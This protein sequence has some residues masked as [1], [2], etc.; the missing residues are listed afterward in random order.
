MLLQPFQRAWRGIVHVGEQRRQREQ[1]VTAAAPPAPQV[2]LTGCH[3]D[4]RAPAQLVSGSQT[5]QG[6]CKTARSWSRDVP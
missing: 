2:R 6:V 4:I 1:V 5:F 3:R